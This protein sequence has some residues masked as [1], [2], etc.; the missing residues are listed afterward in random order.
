MMI[1]AIKSGGWK[2][3][4]RQVIICNIISAARIFFWEMKK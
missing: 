4:L 1:L 3:R 2:V